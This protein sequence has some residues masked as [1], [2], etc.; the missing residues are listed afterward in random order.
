M[1]RIRL[2][3]RRALT[4][5]AATVLGLAGVLFVAS[6]A[7]A[8]ITTITGKATCDYTKG[9]W[10]ITYTVTPT[11]NNGAQKYKMYSV[12]AEHKQ[13]SS[14]V[15]DPDPVAEK[16]FSASKPYDL[17]TFPYT[18]P[19]TVTVTQR[20]SGSATFARLSIKGQWSDGFFE[21]DY[22]KS[23]NIELTGGC[24]QNQPSPTASF[25]DKCD[26]SVL[27]TLRNDGGKA[28]AVFTVTGVNNPIT[29]TPNATPDPIALPSGTGTITVSVPGKAVGT[30]TWVTPE[31]CAPVKISSKMDCTSLTIELNNPQ[32]PS[33]T[34]TVVSGN[35]NLSG[36]LGAG[37]TKT[38][39]AFSASSGTTAVVTIGTLAPTTVTWTTQEAC[40]TTTP[41]ALAQTGSNLTPL[42]SVGGALFVGGAGMITLLFLLRRRRTSAS[43]G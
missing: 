27:V 8:H 11:L 17:S 9:E 32:G 29:V 16:P 30:H 10:V 20:V 15:T 14:W 6:P 31:D 25:Q 18:I 22:R 42:L 7:S 35:T 34:Y 26:G 43:H 3:F 12:L 37:E 21:K 24:V 13:G 33:T 41:P 23:S 19:T 39:P 2:S 40:A 36:T 38:L 5:A 1:N 4:L 28:D